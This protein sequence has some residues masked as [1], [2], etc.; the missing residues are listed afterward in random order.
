M[1]GTT[2][3]HRNTIQPIQRGLQ[4]ADRRSQILD[5][6]F[7]ESA[8]QQSSIANRQSP[9]VNRQSQIALH[10]STNRPFVK[11]ASDQFL[12]SLYTGRAIASGE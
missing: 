4:I 5:C 8:N 2:S 12:G 9:I 1:C 10:Y 3:F 7:S 6:R 11:G